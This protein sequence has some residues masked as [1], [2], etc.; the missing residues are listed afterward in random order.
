MQFLCGKVNKLQK[1]STIQPSY[2]SKPSKTYQQITQTCQNYLSNYQIKEEF[3]SPTKSRPKLVP[4]SFRPNV[5]V[6]NRHTRKG[7]YCCYFFYQL[8]QQYICVLVHLFVS[9]I[10]TICSS[11]YHFYV[12]YLGNVLSGPDYKCIKFK[13]RNRLGQSMAGMMWVVHR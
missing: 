5:T 1:S 12:S 11:L 9:Q 3:S 8:Q 4:P 13:S 7:W 2:L 10:V 6:L